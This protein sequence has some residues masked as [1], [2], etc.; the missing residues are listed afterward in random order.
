MIFD[1]FSIVLAQ[2]EM[3]NSYN[4]LPALLQDNVSRGGVSES[5]SL[6]SSK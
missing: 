2:I 5:N 6:S 1:R 4:L 3:H